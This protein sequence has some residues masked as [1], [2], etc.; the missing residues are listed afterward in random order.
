[1]KEKIKKLLYEYSRSSRITTKEL[2]KKIR[3]S[4]QSASYLL[5][6]LKKKKLVESTLV[7][8]AVK[9]GYTNVLVGFNFLKSDFKSKKEIID[10]LTEIPEIISIEEG[11]EG[12]DLLVEYSTPNLSAFNKTHTE[13]IFKFFKTLKTTFA[14]PIIVNHKYE[15]NYLSKKFDNKDLILSGDRILKELSRKENKVLNELLAKPNKKL[16]DIS[17]SLKMPVKTVIKLKKLLERKHIIQGYS[18]ILD[19][20][21]LRINRQIIFFRF[22]SEGMKEIEKFKEYTRHNRNI[23]QFTKLIGSSQAMIIVESLKESELIRDIRANFPIESYFIVKSEKVHKKT[24]L[25]L[26][27]NSKHI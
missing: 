11:K 6:T 27:G 22:L 12:V 26:L 19:H 8:D 24:Y 1:M 15:R 10:E 2:G 14:F 17:E 20:S 9:L 7:I 13:I 16:I 5:N 3:S 25:P 23:I 21:K 18:S 4:Q